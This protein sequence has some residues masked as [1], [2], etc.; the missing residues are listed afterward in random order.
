M[1]MGALGDMSG[2]LCAVLGGCIL[3]GRSEGPVWAD[4]IWQNEGC[5][6]HLQVAQPGGTTSSFPDTSPHTAPAPHFLA[7][8]PG[9]A[10]VARDGHTSF[11]LWA[12][13]RDF[14]ADLPILFEGKREEMTYPRMGN[15]KSGTPPGFV[16]A[17][18]CFPSPPA[19]PSPGLLR[20]V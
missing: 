12:R 7:E 15:T 14:T 19:C 3:L 16:S 8:E 6:S 1:V 17:G 18:E 13:S 2:R 10:A 11:P 9:C 20:K 5:G 4:A